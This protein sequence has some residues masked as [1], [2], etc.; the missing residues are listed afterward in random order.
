MPHLVS[1]YFLGVFHGLVLCHLFSNH[2]KEKSHTVTG[3]V[4]S[5]RINGCHLGVVVASPC[6]IAALMSFSFHLIYSMKFSENAV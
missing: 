3:Y 2:R 4:I 5:D 6:P 1:F